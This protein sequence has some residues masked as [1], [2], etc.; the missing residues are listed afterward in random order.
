MRKQSL[1]CR[2]KLTLG[3]R[4]RGTRKDV[5]TMMWGLVTVVFLAST[6]LF[7]LFLGNSGELCLDPSEKNKTEVKT[8][9]LS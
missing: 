8:Q 2:L 9:Y 6:C 4:L 5:T 7:R 1:E 3:T